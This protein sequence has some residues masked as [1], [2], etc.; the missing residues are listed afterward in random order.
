MPIPSGSNLEIRYYIVPTGYLSQQVYSILIVH[1]SG[2][3]VKRML[4]FAQQ[5]YIQYNFRNLRK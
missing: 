3:S 2:E 1:I 5:L 4:C